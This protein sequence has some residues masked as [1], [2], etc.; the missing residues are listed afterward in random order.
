MAVHIG[1]QI[2]PLTA[3]VIEVL[4]AYDWPGNVR[5]LE[6]TI[7][8]A[9][10]VCRGSRIEV[11]DLGLHAYGSQTEVKAP[12]LKRNTVAQDG[13]IMPWDEFERRYIRK[14]LEA[15]NWQIRG[16]RGAATLL[17]LPPSTLYS[18]MKKLGI[19]RPG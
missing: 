9:V 6:Q 3:E 11:G 4:Q 16:T 19:K 10:V 17:R 13:E 12:D 8:R 14:V 18:R 2:D 15:T 7:Q 5:E 1:R